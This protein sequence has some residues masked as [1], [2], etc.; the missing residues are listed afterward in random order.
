MWFSLVL[1]GLVLSGWSLSLLQACKPVSALP[2]DQLCP[3][4]ARV[5]RVVEQPK[6]QVQIVIITILYQLPTVPGPCVLLAGPVLLAQ[7]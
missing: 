7:E 6:L 1:D 4:G 2:G 5:Q 3:G